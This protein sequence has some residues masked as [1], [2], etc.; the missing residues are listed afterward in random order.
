MAA[1][2]SSAMIVTTSM[3]SS[4]VKPPCCFRI[5]SLD[6]GSAFRLQNIIG[7]I[8]KIL[9]L[10]LGGTNDR[11]GGVWPID[12]D[13]VVGAD[14]ERCQGHDLLCAHPA[15][16]LELHPIHEGV[17]FATVSRVGEFRQG[18]R[19]GASV[20]AINNHFGW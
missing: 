12:N 7:F 18:E 14:L 10:N 2:I 1:P 19:D 9:E 3:I 8:P 4:N 11:G 15:S 20:H 6:K 16:I 5:E 17:H 13:D